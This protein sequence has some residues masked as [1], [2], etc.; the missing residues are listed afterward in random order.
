MQILYKCL[1]RSRQTDYLVDFGHVSCNLYPL[2]GGIF[3]VTIP[4]FFVDVRRVFPEVVVCDLVYTSALHRT[5]K[6]EGHAGVHFGGEVQGPATGQ[7]LPVP[8]VLCQAIRGDH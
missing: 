1:F 2:A 5:T 6:A 3:V 8:S 7:K 4:K